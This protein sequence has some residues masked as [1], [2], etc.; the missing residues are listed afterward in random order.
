MRLTRHEFYII[1]YYN[2]I[3]QGIDI[4]SITDLPNYLLPFFA[5]IEYLDLIKPFVCIDIEGGLSREQIAI[6]YNITE[7][8][9][10]G[11]GRKIGRYKKKSGEVSPTK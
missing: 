11:L 4:E 6:K 7:E 5:H 8:K 10:R 3:N 1:K 2:F 9:V